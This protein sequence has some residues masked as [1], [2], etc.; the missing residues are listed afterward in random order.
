MTNFAITNDWSDEER[1]TYDRYS[2]NF[3][4]RVIDLD[5]DTLLGSI[6]DISLSGM[7]LVSEVPLPVGKTCHVRLDIAL[8]EDDKEQVVFDTT[9]IW[10][11]EDLIPGQYESGWSNT[12]SPEAFKSVQR[13]IDKILSM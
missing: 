8:G 11:R 13:L 3:Y 4:L 9:S 12:L 1:R 7:R 2:V 10:T 5:S 6:V